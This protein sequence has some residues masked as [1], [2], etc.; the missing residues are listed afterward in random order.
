LDGRLDNHF[1]IG[2]WSDESSTDQ[3]TEAMEMELQEI[4]TETLVRWLGHSQI[5]DQLKHE[6]EQE[7]QWNRNLSRR[8]AS[9]PARLAEQSGK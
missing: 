8:I 5:P 9:S 7:L 2:L 3:E 1:L 4:K 6:I